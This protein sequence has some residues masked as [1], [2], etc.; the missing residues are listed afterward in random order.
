MAKVLLVMPWEEG[1]DAKIHN[2]F[3]DRNAVFGVIYNK[4]GNR[5]FSQ[6]ELDPEE[7]TYVS[8][9]YGASR[10]TQEIYTQYLTP[11]EGILYEGTVRFKSE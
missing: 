9:T 5:L 1:L 6:L 4:N 10:P 8:L 3:P 2:T 7:E 11:Y